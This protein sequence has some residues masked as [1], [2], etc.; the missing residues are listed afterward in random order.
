MGISCFN[1]F[2][3]STLKIQ[4]KNSTLNISKVQATHFVSMLYF[5]KISF[6][7]VLFFLSFAIS[8]CKVILLAQFMKTICYMEKYRVKSLQFFH[9]KSSL[10]TEVDTN[11][12]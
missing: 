4:I 5:P 7:F 10:S 1:V 3:R 11:K 6:N 2:L 8:F 12:A 9:Q